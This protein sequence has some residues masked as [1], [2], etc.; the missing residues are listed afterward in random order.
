M[1]ST[2][3]RFRG[4]A[5]RVLPQ[6]LYTSLKRRYYSYVLLRY[7]PRPVTHTYGGVQLN[8][9]LADPVSEDWYDCD[10]GELSEIALLKRSRLK[11]GARVFNLG[12]HQCVVAMTLANAVRPWGNIIAVEASRHDAHT[13]ETNC[14]VNDYEEVGVPN[15]AAAASSG[16]ITFASEGHIHTRRDGGP[17][18]KV[19]AWSI[20]HLAEEVAPPDVVYMD[21]EDYECRAMAGARPTLQ[22]KNDWFVEVHVKNGLERFGGSATDLLGVFPTE[23]F[24]RYAAAGGDPDFG[25]LEMVDPRPQD[26]FFLVA[27]HRWY[28]VENLRINTQGRPQAAGTSR[29]TVGSSRD[30]GTTPPSQNRISPTPRRAPRPRNRRPD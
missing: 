27:L 17:G 8:V 28:F 23:A 6:W 3:K 7:R 24:D 4:N 26:R 30:A 12:A 10:H 1:R 2:I 15:P 5:R 19:Q 14:S 29:N 20:D 25:P 11:P 22:R 9:L 16:S 21:I 13:G 18:V